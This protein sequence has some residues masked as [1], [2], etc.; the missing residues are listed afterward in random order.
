MYGR[1]DVVVEYAGVGR[2]R[3]GS[4]GVRALR[5]KGRM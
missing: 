5:E 3:I 4:G 1:G 2:S